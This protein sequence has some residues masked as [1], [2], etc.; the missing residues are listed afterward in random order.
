MFSLILTLCMMPAGATSDHC[1]EAF[2]ADYQSMEVC[3]REMDV[4]I[5]RIKDSP[6]YDFD[7]QVSCLVPE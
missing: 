4:Q 2:L 3:V 7:W 6:F 1:E 5:N